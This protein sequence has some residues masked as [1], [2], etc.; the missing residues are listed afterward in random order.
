[1][2]GTRSWENAVFVQDDWRVSRR[3]TLNMGLRYDVLTNPTEVAGPQSNFD[4]RTASLRV[5]SSNTDP[6]VNNNYH[7][8][9]PRFGFAY[10]VTGQGKTVVR[11]GFGNVSFYGPRR[12]RQPARAECSVQRNQPIQLHGRLS[13]YAVGGGAGGI[14]GLDGG[15]GS[16]SGG[17]LHWHEPGEPAE[18]QRHRDQTGQPDAHDGAMEPAGAARDAKERD[19][20]RG[21][22]GR[23]GPAPDRSLYIANQV[24][25]TPAGTH[26]YPGMGSIDV[27]EARD[28]SIYYSL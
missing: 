23:G 6:L 10:D 18:S 8:F 4:L 22:C 11:G 3:L 17:R 27:E 12:N 15:H 19:C 14:I 16:P 13:D 5:A 24:F 9:G 25:N 2:F 26:L 7:N 20:E 28:N 1:M 21:L